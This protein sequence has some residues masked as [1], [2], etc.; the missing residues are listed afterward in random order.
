MKNNLRRLAGSLV[1]AFSATACESAQDIAR[2]PAIAEQMVETSQ[3]LCTP[4]PVNVVPYAD[5]LRNVLMDTRTRDLQTLKDNNITICMD[6]RLSSQDQ[7]ILDIKM[8][9]I[10]YQNANVVGL[11]DSGWPTQA[12]VVGS[13]ELSALAMDIRLGKMPPQNSLRYAHRYGNRDIEVWSNLSD[14]D[15]HLVR[16]PSLKSPP[17]KIPPAR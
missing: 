2:K 16:N 3:Q 8:D 14:R 13:Q 17:L 7:S 9:G 15:Q 6:Q 4:G 12:P 11:W 10:F 5:R 1:L